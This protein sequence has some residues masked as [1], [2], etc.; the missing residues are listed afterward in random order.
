MLWISKTEKNAFW[1]SQNLS[2]GEF[3]F[4]I[5]CLP[6]KIDIILQII[7]MRLC[8]PK[9]SFS[10][11]HNK[12]LCV[13]FL[14]LPTCRMV[15]FCREHWYGSEKTGK[16][17]FWHSQNLSWGEFWFPKWY[18]PSEIDIIF[19]IIDMKLFGKVK[20]CRV[21]HKK[22]SCVLFFTLPTGTMDGFADQCYGTQK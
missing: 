8:L 17:P 13:L 21:Y 7:V 4:L 12:C 18:L 10:K 2:W 9:G 16:N 1:H 11:Y 20:F 19:L 3:W 5:L 6:S 15:W 14:S 22:C